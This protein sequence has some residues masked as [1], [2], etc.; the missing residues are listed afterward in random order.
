[1]NVSLLLF[2]EQQTHIH[3]GVATPEGAVDVSLLPY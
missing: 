2:F 3:G 1:M